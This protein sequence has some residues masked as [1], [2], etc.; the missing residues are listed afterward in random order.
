MTEGKITRRNFIQTVAI[1]TGGAVLA[2]CTPSSTPTAA[3]A[4]Q[5]PQPTAASAT[6]TQAAGATTAPTKAAAATATTTPALSAEALLTKAGLPL[7]GA[8]TNPK[9]WKVLFPAVPD[10]MPLNP[11]V[12]I[13]SSRR[14]DSTVSFPEG[15]GVDNNFFTRYMKA[16]LG[17]D[18]KAAWTM[19]GDDDVTQKYN[20]AMAA[21]DL[22]DVCEGVSGNILVKMYE[23]NIVE[24]LTDAFENVASKKWVKDPWAPYGNLPWSYASYKGRKMGIPYVERLVQNDKLMWIRQDWLDKLS[25]KAPT[26]LD[27]LYTVA[28]AFKNAGL[29]QGAKGT[30]L[31]LAAQQE[32]GSGD[33]IFLPGASSKGILRPD[34]HPPGSIESNQ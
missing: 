32:L 33:K 31:G 29:G 10:G 27:E 3:P 22:P 30:T 26:T 21:N 7:P 12:S 15:D 28:T 6:A 13:S 5:A 4:T 34:A 25:L 9:G 19:I 23:A 2:A 24:D 8:P 20:T 14:I 1:A 16:I 11:L 18:W 17:I